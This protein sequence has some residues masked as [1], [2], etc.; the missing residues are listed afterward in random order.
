[1]IFAL[2]AV[3]LLIF[4]AQLYPRRGWYFGVGP[5]GPVYLWWTRLAG[6][7]GLSAVGTRPGVPALALALAGTM[8]S[9]VVESLAAIGVVGGVCIGLA[10]AALICLGTRSPVGEV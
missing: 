2:L 7:D 1:M 5:D 4:F 3:A 6:H 9:S 10:A 8:R